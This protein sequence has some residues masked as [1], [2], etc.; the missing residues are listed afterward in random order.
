MALPHISF[1]GCQM[2]Y[3]A[4]HGMLRN[5][6]RH[7]SHIVTLSY[8]SGLKMRMEKVSYAQQCSCFFAVRGIETDI[9]GETRNWAFPSEINFQVGV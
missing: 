1:S 3:A 4:L 7:G 9:E 8:L 2:C 5:C 6:Y